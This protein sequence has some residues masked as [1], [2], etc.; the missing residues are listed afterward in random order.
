MKKFIYIFLSLLIVVGSVVAQEEIKLY[1]H[2]PKESNEIKVAESNQRTDF[3]IDIS[4]PRMYFYPAKKEMNT[5]TAV[6]ICPGGGY[7]GVSIINEGLNIAKWFNDLGI[8]AFV[9]Y[10]R[11]PNGHTTVPLTDAQAAL[12][13]IHKGAK[14]WGIDKNKIGIMG[15]SAGGHLASTVGTHFRTKV[16]RP[17]FMILGYPVV[18]MAKE[19]THMGS[20]YN[21]LGK[22][23]T[24]KL[25]ALY[26]N[27]LQVT[28]DTPPTFIVH[29]IDDK[30]V[31]IANSEQLIKTLKENNVPAELHTFDEGGH[32]FG[33]RKRGIPVDNWS[34][35]LKTWLQNNKLIN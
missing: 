28:K 33:M 25:V 11:M 30:T 10:Y 22:N 3:V 1:K 17:A 26:S 32:G 12:K 5:G 2:G 34:D 20:R 13:I 8:N 16:E 15:F 35:L 31:P 29:A 4:N 14:K 27:E 6:L 23:P 7:A 21:L 9:L 24:D 19:L 18:T